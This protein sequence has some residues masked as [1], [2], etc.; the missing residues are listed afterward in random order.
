[1][2]KNWSHFCFKIDQNLIKNRSKNGIEFKVG[3]G[4][5]IFLIFDR[6]LTN[7]EPI[8]ARFWSMFSRG[9]WVWKRSRPPSGLQRLSGHHLG[10]FSDHFGSIFNDF[11]LNFDQNFEQ[12]F[13]QNHTFTNLSPYFGCTHL[14]HL[15]SCQRTSF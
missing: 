8:L 15:R 1:M 13:N 6:F 14:P 4:I 5:G 12:I 9:I 10:A 11:L 3:F 7:F 2:I